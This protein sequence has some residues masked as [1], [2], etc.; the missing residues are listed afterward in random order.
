MIQDGVKSNII[1][2]ADKN[3]VEQA[4]APSAEIIGRLEEL[5]ADAKAGKITYFLYAVVRP[6][7]IVTHGY[8]SDGR[9]SRHLAVAAVT[10][11]HHALLSDIGAY[12]D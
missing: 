2:I 12:Y 1:S 5:L 4:A 7:E 9:E 3:Y 10:Y 8:V 11:L 6:A